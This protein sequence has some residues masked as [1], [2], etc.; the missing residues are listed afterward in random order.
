MRDIKVPIFGYDSMDYI[1]MIKWIV[2]KVTPP[3]LLS[4]VPDEEIEEM[5]ETGRLFFFQT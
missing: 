4:N 5:I 1:D 2:F 3:S